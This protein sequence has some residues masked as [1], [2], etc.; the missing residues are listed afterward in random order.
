[1]R[2][3]SFAAIGISL[4]IICA[5]ASFI[6]AITF[7][8]TEAPIKDAKLRATNEAL[9]SVLPVFDNAPAKEELNI[10]CSGREVVFYPAK[11]DGRLVG[12]AASA[13][14]P[15]GYSGNLRVIA[16][17]TP[18]GKI[19][20]VIVTEKN[21]TPGL[22]TVVTDRIE[23]KTIFTLFKHENGKSGGLPP[24]PVLDS[25]HGKDVASAPW[26]VKKDGGDIDSVTG[27]T[28]SSRAVTDAVNTIAEAYAKNREDIRKKFSDK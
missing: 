6:L 9:K 27:A 4:G 11:K 16:S 15:K 20:T 3:D 21:E 2:K 19:M 25:F 10:D 17:M 22:G 18:D 1:M 8:C 23:Q 12:V 7:T 24:N 5:I 13:V 28:I 26:K 14:S